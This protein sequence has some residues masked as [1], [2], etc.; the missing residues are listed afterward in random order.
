MILNITL[1][2]ITT[3]GA[4]VS[5]TWVLA[6]VSIASL[7]TPAVVVSFALSSLTGDDG[8]TNEATRTGAYW[9]IVTVTVKTRGAVSTE[10]TGIVT[11]QVLLSE[12]SA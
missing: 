12:W 4:Q 3:H 8:V 11:A 10:T 6:G 1:G 2:T 9:A 7:V 5:V